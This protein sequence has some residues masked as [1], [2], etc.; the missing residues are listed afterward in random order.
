M[1]SELDKKIGT[2]EAEKLT[3]GSVIVKSIEVASKGE[4][5]KKFKI[6]ELSVMHPDKNELIKL[7]NMKIKKVQGN[8]ETITKDG[9]WYREDKDGNISKTCNTA[10]LLRFY[11]KESLKEL[12]NTSI[13]TELDNAGY[14]CVKAY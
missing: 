1:T 8:N 3:P 13:T 9:I 7:T 12:E 5:A 4:G 6:T 14:L 11:N 2:A 10:Q